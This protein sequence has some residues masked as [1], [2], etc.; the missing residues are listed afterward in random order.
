MGAVVVTAILLCAKSYTV[1]PVDHV[2]L[3]ER[4][5]LLDR[6]LKQGRYVIVPFVDVIAH[7]LTLKPH[8]LTRRISIVCENDQS[9]WADI[10][11]RIQ[12]VSAPKAA[13]AVTNY[14]DACLDRVENIIHMRLD[15]QPQDSVVTLLKSD[16]N[17]TSKQVKK[18]RNKK[19]KQIK[20]NSPKYALVKHIK[21]TCYRELA[22]WGVDYHS[23]DVQLV[24]S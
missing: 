4:F 20:C 19:D 2:Y 5:G 23:C 9:V 17:N 22:D 21:A 10:S 7:K 12:V 15:A 18:R 11:L 24:K 16:V 13:Y 6:S 14:Q 1:V 8:T 3:I